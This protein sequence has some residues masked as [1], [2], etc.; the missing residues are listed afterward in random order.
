MKRTKRIAAGVASLAMVA[1]MALSMPLGAGAA[2]SYGT[3]TL[4][5]TDIAANAE[6]KYADNKGTAVSAIPASVN[7]TVLKK[8]LEVDDDTTIPQCS[9]TITASAGNALEGDANHLQVFAGV[10][11]D[12]I[13]WNDM[14][15]SSNAFSTAETSSTTQTSSDTIAYTAN[16][17][18]TGVTD[19]QI[20]STTALSTTTDKVVISK[21]GDNTYYAEKEIQLD[22]SNCGFTEPGVYR[23]TLTETTTA[24]SPNTGVTN[25][26]ND[27]R[28]LDVYVADA[29]YYTRTGE[30]T[31]ASPYVYT[32]VP[33]LRIEGYVM[34]VGEVKG[35][36]ANGEKTA[37]A[38][39]EGTL[40]DGTAFS[41]AKGFK[42]G[43]EATIAE[44][45]TGDTATKSV[46][47]KNEY[48]TNELKI[49]KTVTGN[50]GSKDKYFKFT[51]KTTTSATNLPDDSVFYISQDTEKTNYSRTLTGTDK[52][53]SATDYTN[54][55][56]GT[57]NTQTANSDGTFSFT[58]A[59]LRTGIDLYLQHDQFVTI[60]GLPNGIDYTITEVPEDYTASYT[61]GGVDTI[62]AD[63]E[64]NGTWSGT[65]LA[66][67]N[68]AVTDSYLHGDAEAKFSNDKTGT[69]RTGILLSVAAP[70]G[71]GIVVI[72]GIV[73][74][75][76]KNKRREAEEE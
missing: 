19:A 42:N 58:A 38:T 22:F 1:S 24:S 74:L 33:Q 31:T 12:K 37:G 26:T 49:S 57:A 68:N 36:P 8:V 46:G 73:Y 56:I 72:G 15:V 16:R 5:S 55:T 21:G 20:T 10:G 41:A 44:N 59:Q 50:Q 40:E 9:F 63:S 61:A 76:I 75:L 28:T 67:S 17:V 53:N 71:V 62:T 13:V 47:F 23:Y 30:G 39:P 69:I 29:S 32:L 4:N 43:A 25:D 70:A 64:S 66:I 6:G 11:Y 60:T 52:P 14:T 45:N 2:G 65:A 34:Y 27:K 18:T 54:G 3:G 7:T 48:H 51:L 35:A